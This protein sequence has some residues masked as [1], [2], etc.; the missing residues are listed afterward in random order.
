[1]SATFTPYGRTLMGASLFAPAAWKSI[2][3]MN[4]ALTVVVPSPN[5][6]IAQLVEPVGGGYAQCAYAT[7]PGRWTVSDNCEYWNTYTTTFAVATGD[8]GVINGFA[9]LDTPR[10]QVIAVGALD[11]PYRVLPGMIPKIGPGAI[12]LG[13]YDN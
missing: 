2:P 8:W 3:L 13:I 10:G 1:M 6:S 11:T 12:C 5:D 7:D 4:I 9:L